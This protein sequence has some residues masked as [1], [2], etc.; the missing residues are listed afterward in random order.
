VAGGLAA[1]ALPLSSCGSEAKQASAAPDLQSRYD[2]LDEASK[3]PVLKAELFSTPVIIETLEL[4]RYKG[5][6]LCIVRSKDGAEGNFR[7]ARGTFHAFPVFVNKLQKF[8]IGQDARQLDLIMDRVY[9]Y[10]F[11][12]R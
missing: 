2:R 5:S 11:N 1:G 10:G 12:F 4:L 6:F 8:C 7:R 9:I 3:Q